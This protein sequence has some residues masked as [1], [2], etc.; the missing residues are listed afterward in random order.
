[1]SDLTQRRLQRQLEELEAEQ[2]EVSLLL[3]QVP[4]P[5]TAEIWEQL[6]DIDQ[7]LDNL[8]AIIADAPDQ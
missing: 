7:R 6:Q 2:Q 8:R 1:M 4:T 3:M 5:Q